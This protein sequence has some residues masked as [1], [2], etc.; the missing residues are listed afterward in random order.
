[1]KF[2]PSRTPAFVYFTQIARNISWPLSWIIYVPGSHFWWLEDLS[3]PSSPP[4]ALRSAKNETRS[5]RCA[6]RLSNHKS[7]WISH[8]EL[9]IVHDFLVWCQNHRKMA[10]NTYVSSSPPNL[11]SLAGPNE[12]LSASVQNQQTMNV[13][14]FFPVF[15]LFA[16]SFFS[17]IEGKV[18]WTYALI[19]YSIWE[20][21]SRSSD[22]TT[23]SNER[24]E[25]WTEIDLAKALTKW[26][27]YFY[28][29]TISSRFCSRSQILVTF[30]NGFTPA[31]FRSDTHFV[32]SF[33][34]FVSFKC[35]Y[36]ITYLK[37]D[38]PMWVKIDRLTDPPW[39]T[40]M[41]LRLVPMLQARKIVSKTKRV[42]RSKLKADFIFGELMREL[43]GRLMMVWTFLC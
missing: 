20:R 16:F 29:A 25:G 14:S 43:V 30:S 42:T 33:G 28:K 21:G 41:A 5:P 24:R 22:C 40:S 8:Y 1:M 11:Q 12:V 34:Y 31:P 32:G 27:N 35:R 26:A 7:S 13:P 9:F 10:K 3:S 38:T 37:L 17:K 19:V 39:S 4:T 6:I 36:H 2:L 23:I 15:V 18:H